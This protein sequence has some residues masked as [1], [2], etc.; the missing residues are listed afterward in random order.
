M[1]LFI[2]SKRFRG[3]ECEVET[4]HKRSCTWERAEV[5]TWGEGTTSVVYIVSLIACEGVEVLC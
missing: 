1:I 2:V 3:L 4:T 5:V